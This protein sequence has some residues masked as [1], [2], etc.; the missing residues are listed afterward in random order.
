M[1]TDKVKTLD[2]LPHGEHNFVHGESGFSLIMSL[3][4]LAL[5]G[6]ISSMFAYQ[7]LQQIRMSD[8]MTRRGNAH[9]L[10]RAGL[11]LWMGQL[12]SDAITNNP[13][14]SF[15]ENWGWG[16]EWKQGVDMGDTVY[17]PS[18]QSSYQPGDRGFFKLMLVQ[19]ES[20]KHD[21]RDPLN[22]G[23]DTI[24]AIQSLDGDSDPDEAPGLRTLNDRKASNLVTSSS[25]PADTQWIS[26]AD[27]IWVSWIGPATWREYRNIGSPYRNDGKINVNTAP[28]EAL[29]GI[30]MRSKSDSDST[31]CMD[32]D[33]CAYFVR[34]Q[35]ARTLM[36]SRSGVSSLDEPSNTGEAEQ[37]YHDEK[38][39]YLSG[40]GTPFT[41]KQ[42]ACDAITTA[43]P[44]YEMDFQCSEFK[45]HIRVDSEGVF[46]VKIEGGTVNSSGEKLNEI[47]IEAYVDRSTNPVEIIYLRQP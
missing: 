35:I 13:Y 27:M 28:Y 3:W 36:E 12:R 21:L 19:D 43:N 37:L 33:R 39:G 46:R 31:N 23:S 14:D 1:G 29:L 34:D 42:D 40:S 6:I 32:I 5:I 7:A 4:L 10:A 9:V 41:T 20:G 26:A 16:G 30:Q 2:D 22:T 8:A 25:G 45:N 18:G 47:V 38:Q 15:S 44:N 11:E 24:T 17:V